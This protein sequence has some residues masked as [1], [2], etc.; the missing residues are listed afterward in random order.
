MY[1]YIETTMLLD[2]GVE[3]F[4]FRDH[5]SFSGLW[6]GHLTFIFQDAKD[7][8]YVINRL[9]RWW[10]CPRIEKPSIKRRGLSDMTG[11]RSDTRWSGLR[12]GK[13]D[14]VYCQT[15]QTGQAPQASQGASSRS[16]LS[17]L[18]TV[19]G[20]QQEFLLAGL[21]ACGLNNVISS[22]KSQAE[23]ILV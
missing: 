8:T 17:T 19:N 6:D 14:P 5:R 10:C 22:I 9:L 16:Q 23:D 18:N 21:L 1:A 13:S 11:I 4:T 3:A 15:G 7:E 2:S 12:V 20:G